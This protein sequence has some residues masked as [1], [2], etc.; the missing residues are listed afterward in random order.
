[1][2]P[3]ITIEWDCEQWFCYSTEFGKYACYG[4][5]TTAVNALKDFIKSAIDFREYLKTHP[6]EAL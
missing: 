5:G 6:H 3:T 2:K 1:M 4:L